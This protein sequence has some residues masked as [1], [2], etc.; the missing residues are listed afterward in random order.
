MLWQ[1]EPEVRA[2]EE[3]NPTVAFLV[4]AHTINN[5]LRQ[6]RSRVPAEEEAW[7]RGVKFR[8]CHWLGLMRGTR[9]LSF[10]P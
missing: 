7:Q 9:V 5:M 8:P 10:F 4:S 6:R 1:C 2:R 3:R